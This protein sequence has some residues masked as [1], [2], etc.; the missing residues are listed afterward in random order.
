MLQKEHIDT[1]LIDDGDIMVDEW[2]SEY[3]PIADIESITAMYYH[4]PLETPTEK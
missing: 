4:F 1:V 2:N 3:D